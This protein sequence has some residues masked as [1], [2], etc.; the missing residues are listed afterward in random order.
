M[1]LLAEI[2]S[3]RVRAEI[4]R[5]LFGIDAEE[6]HMRELERRTGCAIGTIQTELKKLLRLGLVSSRRDGNRLYYQANR[7][8]P[9]YPELRGLVLKTVG[10]VDVLQSA[11]AKEA[12]IRVA[13][14]FG[15]FARQEEGASSDID[16]MVIGRL[17]LRQ[18]IGLLAGVAAQVGRE[19]NPHVMA[20]EEFVRRRT[21]G[22]HFVTQVL[23][24]PR[25]FI[26]GDEHELDKLGR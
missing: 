20:G 5:L 4:F 14:V 6:L 2:L 17:G 10:L 1:N 23:A 8:H 24:S 22:E 3:S 26:R 18:L 9:L 13:F 19:I 12:G 21:V 11:L 16:L 15:S 7:Q 25:L